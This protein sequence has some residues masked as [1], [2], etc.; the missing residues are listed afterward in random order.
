MAGVWSLVRGGIEKGESAYQAAL[1]EMR[2]E[3]GLVPPPGQFYRLGT[4]EQFYTSEHD[5]IW[6]CPF[7]VA[8]VAGDAQVVLND[9]HTEFRWVADGRMDEAMTFP[10]EHLLLADV[11]RFFCRD[12]PHPS[13]PLMRLVTG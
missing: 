4:V 11:R 2:E 9:E 13:L 1:R 3:T 7:F 8:E 12:D 6:M 10:N 5:Q